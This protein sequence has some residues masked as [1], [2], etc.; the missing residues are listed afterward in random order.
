MN[1]KT[2][3]RA[4]KVINY[5]SMPGLHSHNRGY[6]LIATLFG[7]TANFAFLR[8]AK[9]LIAPARWCAE[10]SSDTSYRVSLQK[11]SNESTANK[12]LSGKANQPPVSRFSEALVSKTRLGTSR[13]AVPYT[14]QE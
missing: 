14:L 1:I 6:K 4:R 11:G 2:I 5:G 3:R 7:L 13:K 8:S 12:S 10:T 9:L